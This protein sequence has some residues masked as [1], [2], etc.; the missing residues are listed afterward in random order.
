MWTSKERIVV[1]IGVGVGFGV[2]VS[3][4]GIGDCVALTYLLGDG[5][6]MD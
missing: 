3:L 4:I 6:T 1:E 2:A 5:A